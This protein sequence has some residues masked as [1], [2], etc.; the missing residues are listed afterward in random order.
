MF[1][2]N[3]HA[4]E[5]SVA[6]EKCWGKLA[7][8]NLVVRSLVVWKGL[9]ESVWTAVRI[10][11]LCPVR[12]CVQ[13]ASPEIGYMEKTCSRTWR[14]RKFMRLV[15]PFLLQPFRKGPH[16]LFK[17]F[18]HSI[19]KKCRKIFP[20]AY[21]IGHKRCQ[22]KLDTIR[23]GRVRTRRS[24]GWSCRGAGVPPTGHT[25]HRIPNQ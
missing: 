9:M 10:G 4:W 20:T 7:M 6:Q 15:L 14:S 8:K 23:T 24:I 11:Y 18:V 3:H 5:W 2:I 1:G 17:R 25:L 21:L 13:N 22:P 16:S 19:E 12:T